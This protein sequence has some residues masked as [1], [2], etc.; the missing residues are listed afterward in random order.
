MTTKTMAAS[1]VFG[2]N[3]E[4]LTYNEG[5]WDA[6]VK[7]NP[8]LH[9]WSLGVE[10]QFYIFWPLLITIILT[11][12]ESKA[13]RILSAYTA[14]SFILNIVAV[15]VSPKFAFYFPFCRFWQ[16]AVGGLLAFK[17][18]KVGDNPFYANAL[19]VF[20]LTTILIA[21]YFLSEFN[22]YP[23]WWAL[24]PTLASAAVILAGPESIGNK[25]LLR[26]KLMVFVGKVSYSLYLWHW[27]LLVFS[28]A[29]YPKDSDLLLA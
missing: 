9:L 8:L 23:G 29:F 3:I 12:F 16:M 13:L 24:L 26:N 28:K 17:I 22:L 21:S 20:G 11:K 15:Y 10:E 5:Y 14:L 6:S 1:T 7:T 18:I 25:Y 2:A 27:P 4:V 19:S